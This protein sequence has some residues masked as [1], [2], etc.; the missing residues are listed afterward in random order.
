MKKV[1]I[2]GASSLIGIHIIEKLLENNNYEITAINIRSKESYQKMRKFKNKINILFGDIS[3]E[4]LMT[5]LVKNN[6]FII[7]CYGLLPPVVNL[8]ENFM[9]EINYKAI[10]NIIKLIDFF[11][12]KCHLIYLSTTNMYPNTDKQISSSSKI[13]IRKEDI[14]SKYQNVIEEEIKEKLEKY[15]IFR[16]PFIL[17][18]KSIYLYK[19]NSI[20][21]VIKVDDLSTAILNSL[22]KNKELNKKVKILSGGEDYRINVRNLLIKLLEIKGFSFDIVWNKLFNPVDYSGN[23]F[24]VDKKLDE[25]LLYKSGNI[26]EYFDSLKLKYNPNIIKKLLAKVYIRKLEK[27][28]IK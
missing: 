13:F 16:I 17:E 23:I 7:N 20:V 8:K 14:Y 1:L 26:R 9:R 25:I 12:P 22:E 6:D 19:E 21:E 27:K 11:N 15:T 28:G 10:E 3:D 18:D 5:N 2:T 24:R 4:A